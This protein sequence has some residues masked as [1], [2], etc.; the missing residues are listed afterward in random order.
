MFLPY[1]I[2]EVV[3]MESPSSSSQVERS[4]TTTT[5]TQLNQL[6][7]QKGEHWYMS[8]L[9]WLCSELDGVKA[10][11]VVSDEDASGQFHARAVWPEAGHYDGLLQ[12]AAETALKQQH[13]IITPLDDA[14]HHVGSLTVFIDQRLRAVVSLLFSAADESVM[15]RTLAQVEVYAGW[16][17]LH[18]S[19][20]VLQ[21]QKADGARKAAVV[22]AMAS[23]LGEHDFEHAAL[24]FVNLLG[25]QLNAERVVLGLIDKQEVAIH[26]QSD[27][28]EVSHKHQL[29]Q[30]TQKALQECADQRESVRWPQE[31]GEHQV[32]QALAKLADAEGQRALLTVPLIDKELCYGALLFE[33]PAEQPFDREERLTAEALANFVGVAL[34]EKRQSS[35]PLHRYAMR[36]VRNQLSRLMGP[37]YLG[38]K[39]TLLVVVLA[40]LFFSFV[41]G[42]YRISADAVL[43]GAELRA[44]VVPFDSYLQRAEARAGDEIA[45]ATVLAELD[46]RELRLQRMS[47]LSQQA[48]AR[49]QYEDALAR[50]ERA[51][52]QVNYAQ[53][54]RA[55]AELQLIDYQISQAQL[56]APFDA[57]VVSGDLSQRIGSVVQQGEVLFELSPSDEFRL[58]LYVNEFRIH[59][60]E[61][62]QQGELVLAALADKVFPLEITRINPIAEVRDGET[63]YRVE[64]KLLAPDDTLRVGLEGVAQVAVD[65]RLLIDIWTRGLLDWLRLRLWAFWG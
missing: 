9:S 49:R 8:W 14:E 47:W 20:D 65:R 31:P 40:T 34:E 1:L 23:I 33:R 59:D 51:Q 13:P 55:A 37:G 62:G 46:T 63:V 57:L 3:C 29:T 32:A 44:I 6:L 25:R 7:D 11:L 16:L 35:L 60:I 24:R 50:Q 19:R 48:T 5:L 4:A 26:S 30:L 45:K 17:E 15:Q 36:S 64:A 38:R 12:D 53:M 42:A 2:N 61:A 10:A 56:L 41:S 43:E 18:L 22:D 52:V 27:S 58:A 21:H 54:Q 39:V 28:S